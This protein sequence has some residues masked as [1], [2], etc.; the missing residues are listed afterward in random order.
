[1]GVWACGVSRSDVCVCVCLCVNI[2][3]WREERDTRMMCM[4]GK[5]SHDSRLEPNNF[6]DHQLTYANYS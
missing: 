6:L 4:H 5:R 2:V 1:V 3:V